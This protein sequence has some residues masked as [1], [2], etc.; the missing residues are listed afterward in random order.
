ML[1]LAPRPRSNFVLRAILL[2]LSESHWARRL[3]TGWNFPRRTASRF[4][5][6]DT[7]EEALIAVKGLNSKGLHATLDHLGENVS[8]ASEATRATNTYIEIFRK[9]D[10]AGVRSNVSLKLSQLGLNLDMELCL[11]NLL[12]IA[13]RAA[14]YNTFVRIDME[15]SPTVDPTIQAFEYI[16]E[17]GLTNVGLVI[18]SYLYRSEED[19]RAILAEGGRIRL[20]K[21]A[22][23]EPAEIAFPRK[24]EVDRNFDLLTGIMIDSA[25]TDGSVPVSDYGKIP[26]VTAIATHDPKRIDYAKEYAAKKNFS[27]QALEFQ[28]LYGIRSDLQLALQDEGYPVRVYVPYGTEWYPY[29]MR[30]LA[31]RP[32]NLFFFLSAFFRGR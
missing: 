31:E 2:Y 25:F 13:S 23:N 1:S 8:N 14:E 28:M 4:V 27:K 30:R 29:F 11:D 22:Y 32:A 3:V 12:R 19:I 21:G 5:A 26:P 24:A 6:G 7:F 9:L 18:Q 20:C 17:K 15:D 16:R 10:E